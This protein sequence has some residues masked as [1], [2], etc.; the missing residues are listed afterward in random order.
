MACWVM[1]GLCRPAQISALL[2]RPVA[3]SRRTSAMAQSVSIGACEALAISNSPS[4]VNAPSGGTANG[5]TDAF[6][7][8]LMLAFDSPSMLPAPQ[9]TSSA[10]TAFQAW[11]KVSAITATPGGVGT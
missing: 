4:I 3:G 1:M 7:L 5:S 6:S 8:A 9:L 10:L 11:P 2:T